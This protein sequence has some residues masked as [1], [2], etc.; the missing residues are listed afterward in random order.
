MDAVQVELDAGTDPADPKVQA[1]ARRWSELVE[2]F[3]GGDPG[4]SASLTRLWKEQG[5]NLGSR[6]GLNYNAKMFEYMGKAIEVFRASRSE[7]TS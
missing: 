2:G 6:F 7:A 4:I 5:E 1:L 3:T